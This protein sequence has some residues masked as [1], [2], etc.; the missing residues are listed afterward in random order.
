MKT[1]KLSRFMWLALVIT[2]L[3]WGVGLPA[4]RGATVCGQPVCLGFNPAVNYNVPN[5]A[6]SPNIRKFVDSL[7]G[8]GSAN[9]NNLG[10]YIPIATPDTTTFPGSDYYEIALKQYTQQMHSD[11]PAAGTM[12][13]GYYQV[14]TG[15]TGV[16][17][18]T[19]K[20]LGP[21]I[22]A[23]RDRAVRVKFDNLLGVNGAGNLPIPVDPTIMGAGAGVGGNYTQNRATLH[24][25]GGATPWISDGTPHQWITPAGDSTTLKRGAS[26]VNVP[27][28][29]DPTGSV[30]GS[31][32]FYWTNQQSARLMFYHDHAYGITRLNV[33]AGEA[34]GYLLVDQAE[35]DMISGTNI[36]GV[37]TAASMAPTQVLPDLGGVYHY[38]IPLIIQDKSFVNDAQY[39]S[40]PGFHGNSNPCH[41]YCGSSMVHVPPHSGWRQLVV[42]TR[43]HA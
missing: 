29:P 36:S 7:P 18:H 13:R 5:F 9:A 30:Q 16:T 2:V 27:D 33:Y 25:H 19:Q 24:L 4:A 1:V 15:T 35:E 11:L 31:A 41:G 40:W 43:V 28:M 32:T 42:A 10:Q 17:D 14:N 21:L 38:G 6:N 26:Q 12:L 8:L 23:H 22:I 3:F 20:Y 37:F 34:A 39:A